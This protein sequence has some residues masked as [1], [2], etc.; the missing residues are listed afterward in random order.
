MSSLHVLKIVPVD[1]KAT[2]V[3]KSHERLI[4]LLSALQAENFR[5]RQ[6]VVELSI[7]TLLLREEALGRGG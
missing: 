1:L 7:D 5:L 4:S 3:P 6:A 2:I